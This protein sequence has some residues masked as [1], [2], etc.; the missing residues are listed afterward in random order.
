MNYRRIKLRGNQLLRRFRRM[1]KVEEQGEWGV[2]GL[3]HV[4]E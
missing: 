2:V 3:F 1:K 4:P